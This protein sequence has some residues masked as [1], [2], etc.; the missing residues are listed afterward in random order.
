ML[1]DAPTAIKDAGVQALLV[2][3]IS[4]EGGTVAEFLEIPFITI[5]SAMVLHQ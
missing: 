2:D 1:R 3:Q 4:L 5:C